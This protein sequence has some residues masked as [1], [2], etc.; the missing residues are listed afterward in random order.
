M[1]SFLNPLGLV[2]IFG[3]VFWGFCCFLLIFFFFVG[4]F[5]WVSFGFLFVLFCFF[6]EFGFVFCLVGL[7]L[8]SFFLA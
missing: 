3:G 4:W 2:V 5:F 8:V 7:L 1:R 6:N